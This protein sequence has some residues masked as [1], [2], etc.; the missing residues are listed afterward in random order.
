MDEN[1]AQS[2]NKKQSKTNVN[3][4]PGVLFVT[5]IAIVAYFIGMLFP[6]IGGAISG[7]VIGIL[8][9][10]FLG[11][12]DQFSAGIDFTLKRLLKLA[13]ILLGFSF[14]L[15]DI[16][17]V[18]K[19]SII[20]VMVTV[21]AGLLLTY[22]IGKAFGL[23]GN[24]SFLIGSGT[25]ICGATA[26]VTLSPIIKA[27]EEELTYAVNTI[28]AFNVLAILA[29]PF[30]G[31]MVTMSDYY[32]GIWAGAAIH[33]TSSVVA[34]GYAFSDEA[35]AVSVIVKLA[36]TL[37]LIPLALGVA[38]FHSIQSKKKQAHSEA[39]K[40][41]ILNVFPYFIL[42]FVAVALINTF[43][44][45]PSF[46]P[47]VAEKTAKFL[48]VMVMVSVGLKTDIHKIRRVGYKPLI[49]GLI[50]S[51]LISVI[52]ISLIYILV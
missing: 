52:S 44:P 3:I 46:I 11:T 32:F 39:N 6:I 12:S 26:I 37:M 35:G 4:I 41:N 23:H 21:V 33:D 15:T 25:A 29:F 40:V 48:I 45:L 49:V 50:A 18:G 1:E 9:N 14:Y 16:V 22:F 19:N 30:I 24:T 8:L 43:I 20:I 17:S 47:D 10:Y 5:G 28:F 7:I 13:I 42:L 34:A 51:L 31:K 36:R 38:I 27:K 2:Q